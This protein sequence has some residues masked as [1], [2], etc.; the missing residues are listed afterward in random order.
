MVCRQISRSSGKL[1]F[2][3]EGS[4][5]S[6]VSETTR[7]PSSSLPLTATGRSCE[8][9]AQ[10]QCDDF[11]GTGLSLRTERTISQRTSQRLS[12]SEGTRRGA[13]SWRT[14]LQAAPKSKAATS[15]ALHR[16][17]LGTLAKRTRREKSKRW[18]LM[19]PEGWRFS[20]GK[21]A[22]SRRAATRRVRPSRSGKGMVGQATGRCRDGGHH[23][24]P[25]RPQ[26][27]RKPDSGSIRP[28]PRA[29]SIKDP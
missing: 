2:R 14:G 5:F 8:S 23:G 29:V 9:R 7:K 27:D 11:P 15:H 12:R 21:V 4:Y 3:T 20:A 13:G 10:T 28:A 26:I 16:F 19:P 6:G 1:T 22:E 24:F 18:L 17:M 25:K